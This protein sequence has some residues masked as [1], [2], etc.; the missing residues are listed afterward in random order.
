M[1]LDQ[2]LPAPK[3]VKGWIMTRPE[4]LAIEDQ[5]GLNDLQNLCPDL[6]RLT[7]LVHGFAR[8]ITTRDAKDL[9]AWMESAH[10]SGFPAVR[11]FVNG[12]R[13]DLKA[14][15]AGLTLPYSNGPME[16]ANTKVKILK[17]Q[18]YGRA[19]FPLLRRRI[20]LN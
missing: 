16:G 20:L 9:P 11:S 18:M 5:A 10:T 6:L 17:R 12:L 15:T 3:K 13:L 7:D 2:Q 1:N 19:G 8:M 14:V 4:N